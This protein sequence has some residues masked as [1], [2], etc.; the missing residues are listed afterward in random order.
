M[1]LRIRPREA[2]TV[3]HSVALH[4]FVLVDPD[5]IPRT[6]S[7]KIARKATRNAYLEGAL[8]VV[9]QGV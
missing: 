9:T 3:N 2:V 5:T 1:A 6:S 7:G 8:A 4:D